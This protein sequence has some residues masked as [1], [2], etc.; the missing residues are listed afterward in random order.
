MAFYDRREQYRTMANEAHD[1]YEVERSSVPAVREPSSS[2]AA[3]Y[4]LGVVHGCKRTDAD[5]AVLLL[6]AEVAGAW[7]RGNMGSEGGA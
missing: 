4:S 1:L 3:T 6:L 2:S 5:E 7:T